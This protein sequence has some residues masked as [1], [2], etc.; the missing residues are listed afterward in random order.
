MTAPVPV[1]PE[2]PSANYRPS[3]AACCGRCRHYG[4]PGYD[5]WGDYVCNLHE[6]IDA[7]DYGV[8]NDFARE[9]ATPWPSLLQ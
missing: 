1:V 8:C 9:E 7:E 6:D 5:S 4:P 2:S 3:D